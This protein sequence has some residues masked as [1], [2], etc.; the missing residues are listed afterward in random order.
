MLR[1]K[2]TLVWIVLKKK[3]MKDISSQK[4]SVNKL[5]TWTKISQRAHS[6]NILN[7]D[8]DIIINLFKKAYENND[9]ELKHVDTRKRKFVETQAIVVAVV[10]EYFKLTLSQIGFIIGKHHA[11]T[12]HYINLYEDV[13]C[14]DKDNRDLYIM[15]SMYVNKEIYG[16]NGSRSYDLESKDNKE[17]KAMCKGLIIE[18]RKLLANMHSIKALVNV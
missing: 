14:S 12:L 3:N 11:T 15:L 2:L 18:N 8:K 16:D 17:L 10:Y 6:L 5:K 9:I 1:F 7:S 13:L 4:K